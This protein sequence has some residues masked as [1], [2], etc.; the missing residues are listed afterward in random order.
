MA[1]VTVTGKVSRVFY[2]G[3]GAEVTESFQVRG[4][5]KQKRWT[6]WFD[7]E[8]GLVEGDDVELSGLHGDELNSWEKDGETKYSVKRSLN[9]AKVKSSSAAVE[10]PWT[11]NDD[12][13]SVPF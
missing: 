11:A 8:H 3:K 12:D 7:T 9:K 13:G 4:E 10:E 6:A 2:Q 5:T 1:F